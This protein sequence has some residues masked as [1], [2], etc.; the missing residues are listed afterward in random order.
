[1]AKRMTEERA[2]RLGYDCG[3]NGPG[4]TNCAFSIF[5]ERRF[6]KAWERGKRDAEATKTEDSPDAD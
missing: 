2:Y 3:L 4:L 5:S 1:M 6:T